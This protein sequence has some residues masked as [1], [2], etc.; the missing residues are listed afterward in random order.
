MLKKYSIHLQ[1]IKSKLLEE[2]Y[3]KIDK[4]IKKLSSAYDKL[5]QIDKG[6]INLSNNPD[7]A[8]KIIFDSNELILKVFLAK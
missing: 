4:D 2:N 5:K 6:S 7:I 1:S 8:I 3:K